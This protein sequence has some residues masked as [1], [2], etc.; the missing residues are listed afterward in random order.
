MGLGS[1]AWRGPGGLYD[2][3]ELKVGEAGSQGATQDGGS[4]SCA[5]I[6]LTSVLSDCN[7]GVKRITQCETP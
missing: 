5:A 6:K 7:Q 1:A 2:G 4:A 3:N